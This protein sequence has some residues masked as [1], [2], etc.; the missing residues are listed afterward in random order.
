MTSTREPAITRVVSRDGTEIAYWT[1]G[2]GPPLLLVHGGLGDHSRWAAL[3][4]HLEPHVTVHAMD[5][6]GRGGSGDAADYSIEREYEDVAAVVEAIAESSGAAPDV[7][8]SSYGGLCAFGATALTSSINRLVLYEGWPTLDPDATAPPAE[9]V[10][11]LEE[12]LAKGDRD[13]VLEMA[14]RAVVRL[15]DDEIAMLRSQPN[16][17]ARVAAAHTVPREGRA[18]AETVF[19]PEQ[20]ARVTVPTVLFVGTES[21]A[22]MAEAET[23]SAALPDARLVILEG[24]G[25]AADILAPEVVAE[26]LLPI[27]QDRA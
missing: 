18:F 20:A 4:P 25:H 14:Y 12:L 24:H 17:A 10:A 21:P 23:V 7:Y 27:L 22:W 6:R 2:D 19:D 16:W 11:Q 9:L 26:H 5:R 15:S 13:A 8:C 3:R 1:S